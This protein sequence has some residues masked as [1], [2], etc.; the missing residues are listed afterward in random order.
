M[1]TSIQ[2]QLVVT[3]IPT[4]FWLFLLCC[5]VEQKA[6]KVKGEAV[7][8]LFVV[9][10]VVPWLAS[11]STLCLSA[12]SPS[13][14][15]LLLLLPSKM[16]VFGWELMLLWLFFLF[17]FVPHLDSADWLRIKPPYLI[18]GNDS[19]FLSPQLKHYRQTH[20]FIIWGGTAFFPS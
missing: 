1:E 7:T 9:L 5:F 6:R 12:P 20:S 17:C 3:D 14:L 2:N 16:W 4:L 19:V 8:S 10:C 18:R 15:F 13:A 11:C